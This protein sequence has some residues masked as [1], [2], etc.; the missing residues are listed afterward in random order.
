LA[1]AARDELTALYASIPWPTGLAAA[2]AAATQA[3]L[4]PGASPR[5]VPPDRL[6]L[7]V[8]EHRD[9]YDVWR[10]H[11]GAVESLELETHLRKASRRS[12]TRVVAGDLVDVGAR[13]IEAVLPRKST[14]RRKAA[15]DK[16]IAQILAVNVDLVVVATAIPVD[17][18]PRR[19]L[20]YQTAVEAAGAAML[21]LL[22]KIDLADDLSPFLELVEAELPGVP[23]LPVS[24]ALPASIEALR[25]TMPAGTLT[26]I[27]GSSGVGKSTIANAL[28][29]HVLQ[30]TAEVRARD[31]RG[32]HTTSGRVIVPVPI[33]DGQGGGLLLDSPGMR[34]LEPWQGDVDDT[35]DDIEALATECRFSDCGHETEPG[36]AVRAA[37][38]DGGLD[39]DRL[40]SWRTLRAEQARQGGR[41]RRWRR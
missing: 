11:S 20:R 27:V 5:D 40:E 22:T 17:V 14:L 1:R 25:A 36:C 26:T 32:R 39:E 12:E 15:G 38:D 10:A 23:T 16:D 6:G 3:A 7:V 30:A 18:N 21:V 35:F 13:E 37:I 28:L 24:R 8:G 4:E 31:Q 9:R 19:L 29:G 41:T 2:H 34:E 33:V